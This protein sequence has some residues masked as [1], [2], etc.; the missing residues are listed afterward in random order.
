MTLRLEESA[1]AEQRGFFKRWFAGA[2]SFP[3]SEG[4]T[5]SILSGSV[6]WCAFII[7]CWRA[8]LHIVHQVDFILVNATP[9]KDDWHVGRLREVNLSEEAFATINALVKEVVSS[10]EIGRPMVTTLMLVNFH[11]APRF[12]G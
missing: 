12:S 6:S 8:N 11:A 10:S 2:L 3:P 1:T 4:V 5:A 7:E 9:A